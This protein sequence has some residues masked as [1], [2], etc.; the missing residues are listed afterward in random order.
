MFLIIRS[1]TILLENMQWFEKKREGGGNKYKLS[2]YHF[3]KN[4]GCRVTL[5]KNF[6][7]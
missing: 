5:H 3:L 4:E 7:M 1:F 2:F 6:G